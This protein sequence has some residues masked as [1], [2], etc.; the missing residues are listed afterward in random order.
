MLYLRLLIYLLAVMVILSCDPCPS[1]L[2]IYAG[3]TDYGPVG[4]IL[5]HLS[6]QATVICEGAEKG[7]KRKREM[8]TT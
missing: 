8:Q 5:V 1:I 3:M 7:G 2:G 6:C 4:P